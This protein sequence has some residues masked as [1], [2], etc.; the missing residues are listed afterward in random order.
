MEDKELNQLIK[1]SLSKNYEP[2]YQLNFKIMQKVMEN[3]RLNIKKVRKSPAIVA[4]CCAFLCCSVTV[5][6]AWKYLTPKEVLMEYGNKQLA[7]AFESDNAILMD[8]SQTFGEYTVSLLG[9]VTGS[10]L[11]DFCTDDQIESERTY[12]VVAVSKTDATPMPK[13]SDDY[14]S[15]TSF[16]ISPLI[17][18]FDPQWFNIITM[19]GGYFEIVKDGILYRI[20]ECDNIQLF[21]DR[22]MY[23]CVSNS[24]FYDRNA[25]NYDE[26]TGKIDVNESYKEMNLLFDFP[27]NKDKAH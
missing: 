16:F 7:E 25:Y 2:D 10:N 22:K 3:E 17:Q 4:I 6:A 11:T 20:I 19:N 15:K 8:E 26:K 21:A 24:S 12:A 9:A 5:F 14:Y 1:N 18:G 27:L 13:L 23:L